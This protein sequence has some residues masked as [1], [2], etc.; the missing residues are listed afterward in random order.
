MS[1]TMTILWAATWLLCL[2]GWGFYLNERARS[3]DYVTDLLQVV[4][5]ND[6]GR[7]DLRRSLGHDEVDKRLEWWEN[8]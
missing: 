8:E 7:D 4:Y 2:L 5:D 1:K 6:L 3:R